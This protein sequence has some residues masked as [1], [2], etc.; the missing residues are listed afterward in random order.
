M[1]IHSHTDRERDIKLVL[2]N[3][4]ILPNANVKYTL[5][6]NHKLLILLN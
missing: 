5:T 6:T 3:N 4:L 1:N 2:H